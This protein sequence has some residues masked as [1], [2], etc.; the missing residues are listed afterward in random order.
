MCTTE[1][2]EVLAKETKT[3]AGLVAEEGGVEEWV[4]RGE[5][6]GQEV[7]SSRIIFDLKIW[8]VT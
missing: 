7:G 4:W 6:A 1:S 3:N 2:E 5:E 8:Q